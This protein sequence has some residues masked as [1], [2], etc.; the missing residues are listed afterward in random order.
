MIRMKI[1]LQHRVMMMMIR[2]SMISLNS[3]CTDVQMH[4]TTIGYKGKSDYDFYEIRFL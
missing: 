4:I 3:T 2:R 1:G